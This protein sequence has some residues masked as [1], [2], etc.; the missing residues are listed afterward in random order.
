[1]SERRLC[2]NG[3]IF[4]S[5]EQ[6]DTMVIDQKG[7]NWEGC[8][9]VFLFIAILRFGSSSLF[10]DGYVTWNDNTNDDVSNLLLLDLS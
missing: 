7:L 10:L 4:K 8:L 3:A 9:L 5:D 2:F 6:Y 1:M